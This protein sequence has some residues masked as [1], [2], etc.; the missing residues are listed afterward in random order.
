MRN[1]LNVLI[2]VYVAAA[3]FFFVQENIMGAV[4]G[5]VSD[6][7]VQS[8]P[9]NIHVRIVAVT[10][11]KGD[12]GA[13]A[14]ALT[15]ALGADT[16]FQ[17]IERNQLDALLKEQSLQLSDLVSPDE[18]VRPGMIRGV[19]GIL[20]GEVTRKTNLFAFASC[21]VHL[22]MAGVQTGEI[23]LS[24]EL[25]SSLHSKYL[26]PAF[27]GLVALLVAWGMVGAA[28]NFRTRALAGELD[29][30]GHMRSK[31]AAVF[32][33][34]LD[35]VRSTEH[36]LEMDRDQ[37]FVGILRHLRSELELLSDRVRAMRFTDIDIESPRGL[38]KNDS[39][40]LDV[41]EELL[42]TARAMAVAGG[43]A[44]VSRRVPEIRS[45]IA[46]IEEMLTHRH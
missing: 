40:I 13:L 22:K 37:E 33:S 12:D 16:H 24:R 1:F 43:T 5:E 45:H 17:V 2:V 39:R 20:F 30:E 18:R 26:L 14:R 4:A 10:D 35:C 21:S 27:V 11:I 29:R 38:R 6:Q 15:D 7:C 32:K 9:K 19:E 34:A 31:L 36:D 44:A 46:R 8:I 25:S 3:G 42:D 28:A 41:C 23:L